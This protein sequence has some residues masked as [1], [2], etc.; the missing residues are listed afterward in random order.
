MLTKDKT[1]SKP[2]LFTLLTT[3]I[4][5]L[6]TWNCFKRRHRKYGGAIFSR[7]SYQMVT[8]QAYIIEIYFAKANLKHSKSPATHEA[9]VYF[10]FLHVHV[11]R[12][13]VLDFL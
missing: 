12:M 7:D 4:I 11:M 3:I 2:Q 8:N 13:R 1:R 9:G 5:R 6:P 10:R